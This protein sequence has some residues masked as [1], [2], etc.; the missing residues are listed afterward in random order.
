MRFGKTKGEIR[1]EKG[2]FRGG[3]GV[4]WGVWT[5]YGNQSP[6]PPTLLGKTL[7]KNL[8]F[9]PF[10]IIKKTKFCVSPGWLPAFSGFQEPFPTAADVWAGADNE[11]GEQC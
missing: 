3:L 7:P 11:V 9:R 1:A 6:H 10:L 5:L 4:F 2:D 8:F